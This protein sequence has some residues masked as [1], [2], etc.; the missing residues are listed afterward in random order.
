MACEVFNCAVRLL[1]LW[2]AGSVVLTSEVSACGMWGLA[3]S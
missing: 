1:W 2:R 3:K